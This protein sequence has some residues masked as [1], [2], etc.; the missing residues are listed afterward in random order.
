M[1]SH[2]EN[3]GQA[4]RNLHALRIHL[5]SEAELDNIL[6]S[7]TSWWPLYRDFLGLVWKGCDT[8]H[9]FATHAL[10]S[11]DPTVT[12]LLLVCIAISTG[13]QRSYIPRVE[14]LLVNHDQYA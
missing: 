5:P 10:K 1:S 4:Q 2:D 13:D 14:Q 6:N 3:T 9:S 7:N 8:M 12:A 11:S